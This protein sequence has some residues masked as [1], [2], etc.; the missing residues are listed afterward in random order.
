MSC[1][2]SAVMKNKGGDIYFGSW[3]QWCHPTN[4]GMHSI[5]E[6]VSSEHLETK[7]RKDGTLG[8]TGQGCAPKPISS[9]GSSSST[10]YGSPIRSSTEGLTH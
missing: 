6:H 4:T 3:C 7:E 1:C 5:S 9:T 8:D 10:F 2:H